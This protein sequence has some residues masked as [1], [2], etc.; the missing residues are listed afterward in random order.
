MPGSRPFYA[1][2]GA[3][4]CALPDIA[5]ATIEWWLLCVNRKRQEPRMSSWGP[6][7][8]SRSPR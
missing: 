4:S 5:G 6:S 7:H 2:G 8:L 3:G 1:P